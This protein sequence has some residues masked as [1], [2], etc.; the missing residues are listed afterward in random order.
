[1]KVVVEGY[2]LPWYVDN[3]RYPDLGC[4]D[5]GF[6]TFYEIYWDR[7]VG[8]IAFLEHDSTATE[9]DLVDF[10]WMLNEYEWDSELMDQLREVARGC[11]SL[12]DG[13]DPFEEVRGF[14]R[15]WGY[16]DA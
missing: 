10:N 1:M 7:G 13:K 11:T 8:Q 15:V 9:E 3:P 12:I 14:F 5:N 6:D 4:V 16:G 2:D